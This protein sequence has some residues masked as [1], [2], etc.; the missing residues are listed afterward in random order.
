MYWGIYHLSISFFQSCITTLFQSLIYQAIAVLHPC[1]VLQPYG[2]ALCCYTE[3]YRFSRWS[4]EAKPLAMC[5]SV[6]YIKQLFWH[7]QHP[8][9]NAVTAL[10]RKEHAQPLKLP[11]L[12][13]V[14]CK[15]PCKGE[16][17]SSVLAPF[18]SLFLTTRA[19]FDNDSAFVSFPFQPHKL[20][21]NFLAFSLSGFLYFLLIFPKRSVDMTWQARNFCFQKF[22]RRKKG[23]L[24]YSWLNNTS[25]Y[26][27]GKRRPLPDSRPQHLQGEGTGEMPWEKHGAVSI[28]TAPPCWHLYV[29]LLKGSQ[30]MISAEYLVLKLALYVHSWVVS[31]GICVTV[32]LLR[33][34]NTYTHIWIHTCPL[35]DTYSIP[36]SLLSLLVNINAHGT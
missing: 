32:L 31:S 2:N 9:I 20:V 4:R 26:L 24:W 29:H 16:S 27:T 21:C 19:F 35:H 14:S 10:E 15:I 30:G 36:L 18:L 25:S 8:L 7:Q 12:S 3:D 34:H 1:R 5:G 6:L 23:K 33:W 17:W 11:S 28:S 13:L 22:R